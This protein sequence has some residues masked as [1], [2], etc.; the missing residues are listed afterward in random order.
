MADDKPRSSIERKRS[1]TYPEFVL[2]KLEALSAK[3]KNEPISSLTIRAVEHW[4]TSENY[5]RLNELGDSE[6]KPEE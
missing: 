4:L 2:E 6:Q 3:L 5:R 1:V